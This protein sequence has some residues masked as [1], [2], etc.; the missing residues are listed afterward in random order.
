MK[1][2]NWFSKKVTLENPIEA[3]RYTKVDNFDAVGNELKD[4]TEKMLMSNQKV[5]KRYTQNAQF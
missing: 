2:L 1:K 3:S 5:I 4:L